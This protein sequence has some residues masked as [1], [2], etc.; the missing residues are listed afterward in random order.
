MGLAAASPSGKRKTVKTS[1]KFH[2]RFIKASQS[3]AMMFAWLN[4]F[5][6][7]LRRS[8]AECWRSRL[9]RRR[10]RTWAMLA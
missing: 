1:S 8:L 10:F 7:R 6:V 3:R 5:V 2:A 4:T 9:S